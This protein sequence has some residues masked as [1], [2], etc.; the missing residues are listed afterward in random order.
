MRLLIS[1]VEPSADV[2]GG[3]LLAGL[4]Q[5]DA[6]GLGGEHMRL[7]GLRALAPQRPHA[8]GLV[9][10]LRHLPAIRRERNALIACL[11]IDTFVAIDAPDFHLPIAR[12]LRGR[13]VRTIGYVSPQLWAWRPGRARAVA[14]AFDQLLCLFPF[15]PALYAGVGLDARFVGHPVCDRMARVPRAPEPGC[16]AIFPGSRPQE[17]SRHLGVFLS[18][19]HGARR[20]VVGL[21]AGM[22]PPVLPDGVEALPASQAIACA[23]RAI[24]KSGTITLELALAGVPYIVAHRVH[25]IT[26][27]VGRALVRGVRHLALPNILLHR[28]VVPEFLQFFDAAALRR[29]LPAAPV[30]PTAELRTLLGGGGASQRASECVRAAAPA[31]HLQEPTESEPT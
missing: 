6:M 24:C 7:A 21:P 4:G 9:E 25:P 13:G 31:K 2:L 26:W 1:A 3:E 29:A 30:P 10:V 8:M 27:A 5:I 12:R 19:V 28:Q 14:A 15:E 17:I 20:I 18:A 23:E 16:V 22:A 11:E